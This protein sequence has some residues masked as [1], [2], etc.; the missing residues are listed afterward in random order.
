MRVKTF[1][2]TDMQAALAQVKA[3][4][5]VDA[6]ILSTQ[7]VREDGKAMCEVMAA[8]DE[9]AGADPGCAPGAAGYENGSWQREWFDIKEHLLTLIKPQIDYTRV[10]PR[11]RL[12][13]EYLDREGVEED[14]TLS[15]FRDLAADRNRMIL[16]LLSKRVLVKPLDAVH[17]PEKFQ[18]LAGPAGAGKTTAAIKM[19]LAYKKENQKGRICLATAEGK[20][21]KGAMM[22]R[23]FAELSGFSFLDLGE[24]SRAAVADRLCQDFDKVFLLLPPAPKDATLAEHVLSLGLGGLENL[25]VHVVLNP[26]YSREQL[27]HF[28]SRYLGA[29]AASLVW[30]KCDEACNFGTIINAAVKSGLPVSALGYGDGLKNSFAKASPELLWRLVFKHQTPEALAAP[31]AGAA[32]RPAGEHDGI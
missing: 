21:G 7:T 23:H 30:T 26:H 20:S 27:R 1:R 14:I 6:V 18:A 4:L 11:Q 19:A 29:R 28:A 8:R 22:L 2:G 5:G 17:Y 25:A 15:L 12:A 9:Q 24:I 31:P 10:S 13:L 32:K 16:E 3:D